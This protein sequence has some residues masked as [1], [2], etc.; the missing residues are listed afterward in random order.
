MKFTYCVETALAVPPDWTDTDNDCT[1]I[2]ALKIGWGAVPAMLAK[3]AERFGGIA[4]FKFTLTDAIAAEIVRYAGDPS[5][6]TACAD[7]VSWTREELFGDDAAGACDWSLSAIS[8]K[9]EVETADGP[10]IA[11]CVLCPDGADVFSTPEDCPPGE[12]HDPETG[13]CVPD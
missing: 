9:V 12:H 7:G 6:A 13:E 8:L 5:A 10:I 11:T 4:D 1:K 3:R 2:T